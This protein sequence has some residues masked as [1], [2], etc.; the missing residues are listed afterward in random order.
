MDSKIN[1]IYYGLF[2]SFYNEL[3][4][5]GQSEWILSA[6]ERLLLDELPPGARVLDLCCGS[7]QI[8]RQL[9]Q[10]NFRVTGIDVSAEMIELAR[11]NAPGGEFLCDDART[12]SV[13]DSFDAVISTSDAVDHILDLD[14]VAAVF[15]RVRAALSY[16]GRFVFDFLVPEERVIPYPVDALVD[17]DIV[18]ID[19]G[20]YDWQGREVHI[21]TTIFRRRED[22]WRRHD[23]TF[24]EKLH[25]T[26]EL[27]LLLEAAQFTDLRLHR[28]VEDLGLDRLAGRAFFCARRA[29]D[30]PA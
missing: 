22:G 12:F 10:R 14:E 7:G 13:A 27:R 15:G 3:L 1:D 5:P 21:D 28:A 24:R 4:A 19:R 11:A 17:D 6:L 16:G 8:A 25:T 9:L 18:V 30:I 23:S 26:E 29:E 20:N 2:A